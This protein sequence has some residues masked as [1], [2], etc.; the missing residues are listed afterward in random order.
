LE[1]DDESGDPNTVLAAMHGELMVERR[2]A[3]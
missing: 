2:P 3:D 1:L